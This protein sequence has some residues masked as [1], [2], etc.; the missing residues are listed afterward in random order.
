M[1]GKFEITN[2]DSKPIQ[3][4]KIKMPAIKAYG[5]LHILN[6]EYHFHGL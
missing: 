5:K 6:F 1:I 4:K 2:G 3:I